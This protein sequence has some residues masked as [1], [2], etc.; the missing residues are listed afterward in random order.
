[1]NK[2]FAGIFLLVFLTSCATIFDGSRQS[3]LVNTYPPGAT[4]TRDGKEFGKTPVII[5]IKRK[6]KEPIELRRDAYEPKEV[7][8][9]KVFNQTSI[10]NFVNVYGWLLDWITGSI[11]MFSEGAYIESLKPEKEYS[12]IQQVPKLSTLDKTAG[13]DVKENYLYW[14]RDSVLKVADF[15]DTTTTKL[16]SAVTSANSI[17]QYTFDETGAEVRVL[18]VF[19]KDHSFFHAKNDVTKMLLA[20]EQLHYSITELVSRKLRKVVSAHQFHRDGFEKELNTMAFNLMNEL[21]AQQALYDHEAYNDVMHPFARSKQKEW[22][23]RIASELNE[24]ED[25]RN[26]DVKVHFTN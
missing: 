13:L 20:H 10:Y 26:P 12:V 18:T 19:Y 14:Y 11:R 22:N 4:V 3:V 23:K 25:Y 9:K 6:N 5:R 15:R 21:Y 16:F 8:L 17:C 1:M 7:Y 2:S 24:L